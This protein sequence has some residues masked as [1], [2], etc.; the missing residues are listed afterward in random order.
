MSTHQQPRLAWPSLCPERRLEA[1][2]RSE[3]A[4]SAS[5]S[6]AAS[7]SASASALHLHRRRLRLR[8][9]APTRHAKTAGISSTV[10]ERSR[11]SRA[12]AAAGRQWWRRCYTAVAAPGSGSGGGGDDGGG[13]EEGGDSGGDGATARPSGSGDGGD[14]GG[15]GVETRRDELRREVERS[16]V[17]SNSEDSRRKREVPL[18]KSIPVPGPCP[19]EGGGGEAMGRP[20][21]S[22][23]IDL[24][25]S[26][27]NLTTFL[28]WP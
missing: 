16:A 27:Q 8:S 10:V 23:V 14:G 2:F 25:G 15:R 21:P 26:H 5:A 18:R 1:L 24:I 7:A 19:R 22:L 6:A 3:R 17:V 4:C 9:S 12:A 28:I 11:S 13:G 20:G